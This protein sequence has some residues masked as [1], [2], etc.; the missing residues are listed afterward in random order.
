MKSLTK[1]CICETEKFFMRENAS[2]IILLLY[3]HSRTKKFM[4]TN[5]VFVFAHSYT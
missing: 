2:C 5:T 4:S 1:D 3:I